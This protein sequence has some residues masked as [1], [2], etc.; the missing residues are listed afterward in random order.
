MLGCE[1]ASSSLA[2]VARTCHKHSVWGCLGLQATSILPILEASQSL[3]SALGDTS[4]L[5]QEGFLTTLWGRMLA[6]GS[7]QS[8]TP[9]T[10]WNQ[11]LSGL[12]RPTF[13]A[14]VFQA[15]SRRRPKSWPGSLGDPITFPKE[16]SLERPKG[17][18]PDP[19]PLLFPTWGM[20]RLIVPGMK[21]WGDTDYPQCQ[22]QQGPEG[23]FLL[24]TKFSSAE[25]LVLSVWL[26]LPCSFLIKD[27]TTNKVSSLRPLPSS[28]PSP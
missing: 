13:W 27:T 20:D 26:R 1:D 21:A 24:H 11:K 8:G 28:Q 18:C 4:C 9:C 15:V 7:H 23:L 6:V 2:I 25:V 14:L 19:V 17:A 3:P 16:G 12:E 22:A 5:Q 10:L